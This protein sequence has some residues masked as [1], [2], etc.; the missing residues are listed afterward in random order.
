MQRLAYDI[1]AMLGIFVGEFGIESL[2]P[3]QKNVVCL[4][5]G[6]EIAVFVSWH[7]VLG[8]C[9]EK[10][11]TTKDTKVHEGRQRFLSDLKSEVIS[12]LL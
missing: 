4:G 2:D 8:A 10:A 6:L 12:E 3:L 5:R 11:L 7:G 9:V 1:A